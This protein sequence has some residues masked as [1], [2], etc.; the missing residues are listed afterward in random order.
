MYANRHKTFIVLLLILLFN[1]QLKS[2]YFYFGRNKVQYNQFKWHILTTR[3]FELY[4]Y[5]EMRDI[6]E[7]GAQFAENAYDELQT[8]FNHSINRKIPLIFYS[9]HLHF[10]QTNITPGFIPEGVGGFFEFMKGRV[11]IPSDGNLNQFKKV[12]YHELVHVFM[13]S[14]VNRVNYN[15][16]K[17][18]GTFPPLW[19]T[20]GLAEHWSSKWDA[21]A[22]MVLRDAVLNNYMISLEQIWTIQ[23]TFTMY[24]LGQNI[25]D[26]I[27]NTYGDDKILLLMENIWKHENFEETFIETIGKSYREFDQ[28]WL[29]H[30]KK[31][32]YPEL[33]ENDFSSKVSETI[34]TTGY[35]FKPAYYKEDDKE[36]VVF[37]GNRTGYSS[38][39]MRPIK[40]ILPYKNDD[41]EILVKGEKSSDFEA[42]HLFS[43]KIDVN[44]EGFLIFGSK[45]GANDALYLYDIK[46]RR[47]KRKYYF[48]NLVGILSP[49]WSPDGKDIVFAGLSFSGYKD[50]YIFDTQ[51]ETL[52]KLTNDFYDDADPSWSPDGKYITFSSDRTDFGKSWGYNIFIM[53]VGTGEISQITNGQHQDAAPVYSPDGKFIAYTS[54]RNLKLNIYLTELDKQMRPLDEYRITNFTNG[55]FDPEWTD[56][57]GLLFSVY[58]NQ[59]FQIRIMENIDKRYRIAEKLPKKDIQLSPSFWKFNNL[60]VSDDKKIVQYKK[61]YNLDFVQSQVSMDPVYGTT[62]GA[63]LAFTD[64]LGN[65]QYHILLYNTANTKNDLLRSFNF[66]FSK[67]SL[68][69]RTNFAYGLFRLAG[70]RYNFDDSY[71]FEE[72]IGGFVSLHYPFSQFVRL[73]FTSNY[74]YSDKDWF[75]LRERY[76]YLNSNFLSLI[77]DNSIWG[78]TGPIEGQRINLTFGSTFDFKNSTVNYYTI[79]A[80]YRRYIRL[81]TRNAYAIRLLYLRNNGKEARRFY[82]GGSWDLRGYRLWSIRAQNIMFASQELRFPFIDLLGIRFPFGGIGFNAIRGALFLDTAHLWNEDDGTYNW[83]PDKKMAREFW[84]RCTDAYVLFSGF[85][86]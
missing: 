13:H 24:K 60:K 15:H 57:G 22:E 36:Y 43:S 39:Y 37:S 82:M 32:Y 74:S 26:Y 10:Q 59:R 48:K 12:I 35:N 66:I 62:G 67:L 25:L 31:Q 85:Q 80:D 3:H 41:A 44:P 23:G 72:R 76:A 73:E 38:I 33:K 86:V 68:E 58:E 28:E 65:D 30:L 56:D 14:K 75:G 21:Q 63:Q 54:D 83:L 53:D 4:Y 17:R 16:D 11:V 40:P 79:L 42:F 18:F 52:T 20:E 9:S 70:L 64:M 61:K 46:K 47:I 1:P 84:C 45:S 49:S 78:P 27:E 5:N 55:T 34:V 50:L 19:F 81:S 77:K 6:A 29:Y 71:Y 8:K 51:S 69:K 7:K 2:Q